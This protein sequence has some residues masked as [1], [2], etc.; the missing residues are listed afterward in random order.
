MDANLQEIREL[1]ARLAEATR[2]PATRKEQLLAES[3]RLRLALSGECAAV[4]RSLSWL[5]RGAGLGNSVKKGGLGLALAGFGGLL[6][7]K[8]FF[9]GNPDP[10]PDGEPSLFS[11]IAR[12]GWKVTEILVPLLKMFLK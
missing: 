11:K 6:L 1:T 2:S 7:A 8:K 4:E 5:S 12:G 3:A 10:D 9:K